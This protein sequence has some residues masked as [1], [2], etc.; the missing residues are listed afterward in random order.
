VAAARRAAGFALVSSTATMSRRILPDAFLG[1]IPR[2]RG[3]LL[4]GVA[5][6]GKSVL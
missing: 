1:R 2:L 3:R 6:S 4:H 5:N